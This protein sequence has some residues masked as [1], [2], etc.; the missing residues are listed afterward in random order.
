[1]LLGSGYIIARAGE[2][3]KKLILVTALLY[4]TWSARSEEPPEPC[5]LEVPVYGPTG[6][7]LEY[8][9]SAVTGD[10]D[11][12]INLL[13]VRI[14]GTR[15]KAEGNRLLFSPKAMLKRSIGITL[16]DKSGHRIQRRIPLM[17]CRQ[18]TS[19]RH[20]LVEGIGD[21]SYLTIHGRLAGCHFQG[22][23]WVRA[24]PMFG[25]QHQSTAYEGFVQSDGTF[26]LTGSMSGE[27]H[28]IIFGKGRDPVRTVG[29]DVDEGKQ[30][31][32][33]LVE[34]TGNCPK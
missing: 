19:L 11:P 4:G 30:N 22:D 9:I 27:R 8:K 28:L 14:P 10:I 3:A 7:R 1:M 29:F 2:I 24:M 16:E 32:M 20:G 15:F 31:D 5:I 23:W 21:A 6:A 13:S 33:G 18:R 26:W 17:V 12:S 34:L 25:S